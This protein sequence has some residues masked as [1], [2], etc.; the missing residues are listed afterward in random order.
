MS[1]NECAQEIAWPL[2]VKEHLSNMIHVKCRLAVV[3][4]LRILQNNISLRYCLLVLQH[5][6]D[7][8]HG[9][10]GHCVMKVE[11]EFEQESA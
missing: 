4:Y 3:S 11:N 6:M 1:D 7:G 8:A 2:T 9:V 10:C 5:S